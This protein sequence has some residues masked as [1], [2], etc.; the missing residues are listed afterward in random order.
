[1]PPGCET[2]IFGTEMQNILSL[3]FTKSHSLL[4]AAAGNLQANLYAWPCPLAASN[5]SEANPKEATPSNQ[6]SRN[7]CL[8][9]WQSRGRNVGQRR[10]WGEAMTW[11]GR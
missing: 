9:Q 10:D 4:L 3:Y 1:M 6:A 7:P 2:T 11:Q 8:R 5:C